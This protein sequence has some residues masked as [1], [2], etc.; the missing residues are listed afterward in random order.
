MIDGRLTLLLFRGDH[1][2]VEQKVLDGLGAITARP[3]QEAEIQEAMGASPGSLGA[4]GVSGLPIVA[5]N[6]LKGRK[7]M[8]TGADTD[9]VH[10]R[11]V[12]IE[13]DIEVDKWV[14]LRL[15]KS[16]ERCINC[17][18]QLTIQ[19]G[20]EV[21]HI[22]KLGY[23]YTKAFNVN[24]LGRDGKPFQ[25]IM[26]CYGIGVERAIAAA[27][28]KH[29]DTRASSGP[30]HCALSMSHIVPLNADNDEVWVLPTFS[31]KN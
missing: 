14:D 13:R 22:F 12:N 1:E 4:V 2:M 30:L 31:T 10:L 23:T 7:N 15:V 28:E 18:S 5:D 16:G 21:G 29:H 25:P 17:G 6:Q 24:L 20:V 3:A 19:R 9:G 11:G 8:T 26:G 27:V